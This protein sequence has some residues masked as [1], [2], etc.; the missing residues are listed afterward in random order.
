MTAFLMYPTR[1]V[2]TAFHC[3]FHPKVSVILSL[4]IAIIIS[5]AGALVVTAVYLRVGYPSTVNQGWAPRPAGNPPRG[6]GGFPAPPRGK[7][8]TLS[9]TFT[10]RTS[11]KDVRGHSNRMSCNVLFLSDPSPIIGYA[12]H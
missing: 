10:L 6:E 11:L 12:C 7:I 4:D 1:H 8:Q 5:S 3:T 9:V 2:L